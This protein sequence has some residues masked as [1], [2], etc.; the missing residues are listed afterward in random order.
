MFVHSPRFGSTYLLEAD[1]A[2]SKILM[3][4]LGLSAQNYREPLIDPAESVALTGTFEKPLVVPSNND[5]EGN[6]APADSRFLRYL[7]LF[8]HRCRSIVT[9]GRA[10]HLVVWLAASQKR[11]PNLTPSEIGVIV[12]KVEGSLGISECYPRALVTAYLCLTAGLNCQVTVG[13]LVPTAKMHAWCATGGLI[14]FEP[15]FHHWWYS[16]LVVIDAAS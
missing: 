9:I 6:T 1:F 3:I 10:V 4:L 5:I 11:K 13:M 15:V 16:P 7:Y 12:M 8:F 2:T 14:P